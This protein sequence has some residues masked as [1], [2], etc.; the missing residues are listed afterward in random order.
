M[1][2]WLAK[3][4]TTELTLLQIGLVN[5]GFSKQNTGENLLDSTLWMKL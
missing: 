2:V 1:F 4:T 3:R 5:D